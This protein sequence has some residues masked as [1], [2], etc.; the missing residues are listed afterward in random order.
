MAKSQDKLLNFSDFDEYS[1]V[2]EISVSQ[3]KNLPKEGEISCN[4]IC[5][6]RNFNDVEPFTRRRSCSVSQSVTLPN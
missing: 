2:P 5:L 4:F 6:Y 3:P 1:E